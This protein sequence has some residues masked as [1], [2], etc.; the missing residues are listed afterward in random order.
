MRTSFRGEMVTLLAAVFVASAA[1]QS[2]SDSTTLRHWRVLSVVAPRLP[3][4]LATAQDTLV[5]AN[6]TRFATGLYHVR[7]LD[8]LPRSNKPPFFVLEG[9][10]CVECDAVPLI[11][12][13]SPADGPVYYPTQKPY[14]TP[15]IGYSSD[16]E[17]TI[18][19]VRARVFVGTCL[20]NMTV[21]IV[22]FATERDGSTWLS[23]VHVIDVVS[24]TL[25]ARDRP[26]PLPNVRDVSGYVAKGS[27]REL[28]AAP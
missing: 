20:T 13:Q 10:G 3:N 26:A 6:G 8:I 7:V 16:L 23:K 12:I 14:A 22:W 24:D 27:C 4:G 5:L 9:I 15:G 18:P 11:Y 19:I 28:K 21:G 1:A 2:P 17:D 25:R